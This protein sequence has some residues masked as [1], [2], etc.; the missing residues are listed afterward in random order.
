MGLP[1]NRVTSK[2][3]QHSLNFLLKTIVFKETT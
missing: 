3:W 2:Q 1:I